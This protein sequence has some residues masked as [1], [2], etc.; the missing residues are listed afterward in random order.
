MDTL[1]KNIDWGKINSK[2]LKLILKVCSILIISIAAYILTI[3]VYFVLNTVFLN[4]PDVFQSMGE[5]PILDNQFVVEGIAETNNY[6][7][8]LTEQKT[9][10]EYLINFSQDN[11]SLLIFTSNDSYTIYDKTPL[12]MAMNQAYDSSNEIDIKSLSEVFA[13]DVKSKFANI[14][15]ETRESLIKDIFE[16]KFDQI[17]FNRAEESFRYFRVFNGQIQF[18]TFLTFFILL[19]II[20]IK[21][22]FI[23]LEANFLDSFNKYGD[24]DSD[25]VQKL[26][27]DLLSNESLNFS[28]SV[29]NSKNNFL[30]LR[31]YSP[32]SA[33]MSDAISWKIQN[34]D[35]S[36]I[37]GLISV[38]NENFNKRIETSYYFSNYVNWAI[39]L[40]GFIGTI[41]GIGNSMSAAGGVSSSNKVTQILSR[42]DVTGQISVA[43]DTTLIALFLSLAGTLIVFL[44]KKWEEEN[45]IEAEKYCLD[46]CS[47]SNEE[48]IQLE[49]ERIIKTLKQRNEEIRQNLKKHKNDFHNYKI[50]LEKDKHQIEILKNHV[51]ET[52]DLKEYLD[53]ISIKLENELKANEDILEAKTNKRNER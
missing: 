11:N 51:K 30:K 20:L 8:I 36:Q 42:T 2:A 12:R 27:K 21:C 48:M 34:T 16:D 1:Y 33:L 37:P 3:G 7:L 22:Y 32:F 15:K 52:N 23:S 4:K 24:S 38:L 41:L 31:S 53:N 49:D 29:L 47:L 26:K 50:Q 35:P 17:G 39:P 44:T 6:K 19:V 13:L 28:L 43:F 18:F 25:G 10:K 40:I 14:D 46:F 9:K 45:L 5:T